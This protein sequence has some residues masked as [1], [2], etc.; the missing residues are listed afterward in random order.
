MWFKKKE[1]EEEYIP[2][3]DTKLYLL[4]ESQKQGLIQYFH[5]NDVEVYYIT[6][7]ADEMIDELVREEDNM[8][9]VVIDSGKG[10]FDDKKVLSDIEGVVEIACDVGCV[11]MFSNVNGFNNIKKKVVSN[12]KTKADKIDVFKSSGVVDV[13]THLQGY[14]EVYREGRAKDVIPEN[15]LS[16]KPETIHRE[17]PDQSVREN[18]DVNI[19]L[20]YSDE[21]DSLP[22][23]GKQSRHY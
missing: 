19:S 9:L 20:D 23:Y 10:K 5:E 1:V 14:N 22:R 18:F 21:D 12:D 17:H 16:F 8:R 11:S 13:L 3:V 7:D 6:T 2:P 15:V 4:V